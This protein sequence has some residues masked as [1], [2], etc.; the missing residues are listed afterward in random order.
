MLEQLEDRVADQVRRRLVA[1]DQ[2]EDQHRD[3]LVVREPR[4]LDLRL[5]QAGEQI[6]ARVAAAFVGEDAEVG[7]HLLADPRQLG[8]SFLGGSHE[9]AAAQV[10]DGEVGPCLELRAV[11]GWHADDL[12]DEDHRQ[13]I[14]QRGDEIGLALLERLVEKLVGDLA[15]ARLEAANDARRERLVDQAAQA[16]VLGR[17]LPE[18]AGA[19]RLFG[20]DPGKGRKLARERLGILQH[21]LTV[22]VAEDREDRQ[23]GMRV[24]GMI[25]PRFGEELVRIAARAL[26][27]GIEGEHGRAGVEGLGGFG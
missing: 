9:E 26:V 8:E 20:I 27:E 14:G 25:P 3:H 6:L 16:R 12:G 5:D 24:D 23:L 4:A 17:I 15:H 13:R 19:R 22:G 18:H 2:D 1:G 21:R 7:A 11:G 10:G